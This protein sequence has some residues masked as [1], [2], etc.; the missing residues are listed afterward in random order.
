MGYANLVK[1]LL[2]KLG[3]RDEAETL[4]YKG[5]PEAS[6]STL[7]GVGTSA[8]ATALGTKEAVD[9]VEEGFKKHA[10]AVV[11]GYDKA[12]ESA[13]NGLGEWVQEGLERI[14][15]PRKGVA[16]VWD[17]IS[18]NAR[19]LFG[20][21][22]LVG[23][24]YGALGTQA[25]GPGLEKAANSFV[26][27]SSYLTGRF[28]SGIVDATDNI[29]DYTMGGIYTLLGKEE[30]AKALFDNDPA[31][32]LRADVDSLYA[33]REDGVPDHMEKIGNFAETL[34]VSFPSVAAR[35]ASVVA[36]PYIG[37]SSLGL[38]A[39]SALLSPTMA[40]MQA[41]GH[42][43]KRAYQ[44]TGELSGKEF[45]YGVLTGATE[46]ATNLGTNYFL[47]GKLK[48]HLLNARD[49]AGEDFMH[50]AFSGHSITRDLLNLGVATIGAHIGPSLVNGMSEAIE[51][52]VAA[53]LDPYFKRWT[54][55]K[56]A[57]NASA[58]EIIWASIVDG[59]SALALGKLGEKLG[60]EDV[61]IRHA[62][63]YRRTGEADPKKI[64][65][66]ASKVVPG[67]NPITQEI[68][69]EHRKL[70]A[71][72]VKTDGKVVTDEQREMLGTLQKHTA[73]AKMIPAIEDSA[74]SIL[75]YPEA[76]AE[77]YGQLGLTDENGAPIE[78]TADTITEGID[79]NGTDE[80]ILASVQKALTKNKTLA[81]LAA[82]GVANNLVSANQGANEWAQYAVIGSEAQKA[83]LASFLG[84][85][86]QDYAS[87]QRGARNFASTP[88]GQEQIRAMHDVERKAKSV[89][90]NDQPP[91][92]VIGTALADGVYRFGGEN[93]IAIIKEGGTIRLYDYARGLIS[94]PLST[95]QVNAA[96]ARGRNQKV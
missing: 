54:Y 86:A 7:P 66:E 53:W 94:K 34:G 41:A 95:M 19:V 4:G 22:P 60:V 13:R 29:W 45:A 69:S 64:M 24:A 89:P 79:L 10:E 52:G 71:S 16:G 36:A 90:P 65:D 40:G 83:E 6:A 88:R 14:E 1:I 43:T 51:G 67:E 11:D 38:R 18:G 76:V 15:N 32:A 68:R 48:N 85:E 8:P 3:K 46:A 28:V 20:G 57:E 9:T 30:K 70:S 26:R 49:K 75:A 78:I 59:F 96:L 5:T 56:N 62:R 31:D 92:T 93:G 61:D 42:G 82:A 35:V 74:L 47:R 23:Y 77:K 72:L 73:A 33:D 27:G 21:A 2:D 87:M 55:D 84:A 81:V 25:L 91:P 50:G 12:T 44:E 63:D 80:E 37:T 58:D 39:L 17:K